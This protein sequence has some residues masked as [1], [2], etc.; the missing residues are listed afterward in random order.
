MIFGY[1]VS[2]DVRDTAL[3]VVDHDG[4]RASRELVEAMTA[5]GYFRVVGRS[6]RPADLVE[7]LDHGRATVGLEIPPGFARDLG[8]AAGAPVQILVDGTNSNVATVALGYAERIFQDF[9]AARAEGLPAPAVDLRE[10]AWFNADLESR[11]YNVPGVIATLVMLVCLLLTALAVVRE[12]ELGTLEQLMV[13]PLRSVE[14]VAGKALPFAMIGMVDLLLVT[15]VAVLW[16]DVPFRGSFAL[17]LLAGLLYVLS[18]LGIGLLVSTVSR[19]QQEAFLSTFLFFMPAMLL[20]GFLFPVSSMPEAFRAITLVNPI[21]H[22][23]D[24]VRSVFLKG[25]G[26]DVLWPQ[27]VALAAIGVLILGLAASRFRK[28]LD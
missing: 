4:T 11:N 22:F 23:L 26:M 27:F 10:R 17:L 12:R 25:V 13:S 8:T 6:E 14:L 19:T 18:A 5:P 21:R 7:A 16:F 9:V 1:A 20:S 3:F 28:R 15:T 2:T 24:I